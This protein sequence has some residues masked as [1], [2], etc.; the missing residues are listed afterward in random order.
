MMLCYPRCQDTTLFPFVASLFISL[1]LISHATKER[2]IYIKFG[3]SLLLSVMLDWETVKMFSRHQS[4]LVSDIH[5]EHD[6]PQRV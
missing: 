5:E 3:R 1:Y 2:H 6:I 4:G